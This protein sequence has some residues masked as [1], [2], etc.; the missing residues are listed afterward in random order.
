MTMSEQRYK[1]INKSQ[2]AHCCFVATVVDTTRPQ[3]LADG[4]PYLNNDVP[5][6]EAVC[7][8]FEQAQAELVCNAL[9]GQPQESAV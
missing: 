8:C 2:S 5:Q 9:N 4:K 6:Y 1:V 7:E 3:L